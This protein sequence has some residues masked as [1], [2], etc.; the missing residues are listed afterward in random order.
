MPR[1]PPPPGPARDVIFIELCATLGTGGLHE[2]YITSA[3]PH[4]RIDGLC[5]GRKV[6]VSPVFHVV[7][8]VIHECL[9]RIRPK[10]TERSVRRKT[11]QLMRQLS[12]AELERLYE[13]WLGVKKASKRVT[14]SADDTIE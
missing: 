12:E 6:I 5:V 9:H 2:A 1:K 7:E 8:T 4:E 13:V 11:T 10:W 14:V 3:D